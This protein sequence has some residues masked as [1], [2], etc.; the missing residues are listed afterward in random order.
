MS[1][2]T[3]FTRAGLAVF[4]ASAL[5]G[6]AFAAPAQAFVPTASAY[7][8]NF[9]AGNSNVSTSQFSQTAA[10]IVASDFNEHPGS[11]YKF[12]TNAACTGGFKMTSPGMLFTST[13]HPVVKM[14]LY[15]PEAASVNIKVETSSD[16]TIKAAKLV[17]LN[18]GWNLDVTV[19]FSTI[20]AWNV[21]NHYDTLTIFPGYSCSLSN[22]G[23][24]SQTYY[25][26]NIQA[27]GGDKPTPTIDSN[28]T[29]SDITYGDTLANSILSGGTADVAGSF[30]FTTPSTAPNAGTAAQGYTF[31]PTDTHNYRNATSSTNVT[32]NKADTS[33]TVVPS[34]SDLTYGDTL[35]NS[36][37]SG[38]SGSVPG[39][40]AFTSPTTAPNAGTAAQGV[41]FT[42][43]DSANYNTQSTLTNVTVNKADVSITVDP[44]ASDITYGDTLAN[45]NLSGGTASVAGSFAFTSPTTAPNAGTA[46]QGVTF[47]PA[48]TANYSPVTTS[49]N[50]K[51][52][53]ATPT[54]SSAPTG[55]TIQYGKTLGDSR[56]TGGLAS[57]PGTFG[58]A[59]T[60]SVPSVGDHQFTVVF[61]P[62][63]SDNY[64][65]VTVDVSVTVVGPWINSVTRQGLY[66]YVSFT[67]PT[68]EPGKKYDYVAYRINGG[69]WVNWGKFSKSVQKLTGMKPRLNLTVQIRAH[70][71]K[72]A[73]TGASNVVQFYTGGK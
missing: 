27:N 28:P 49:V 71:A 54:I 22:G 44:T 6:A 13:E 62:A 15:S 33:I 9:E 45:S 18:A 1:S 73:W 64:E 70:V 43:T 51:V 34:A 26:D 11:I 36:N 8:A 40:F 23:S 65:V 2:L 24:A 7:F 29:A 63:D 14:D 55:G 39:S 50:V 12:Q 52:N 30:A 10:G 48:D 42:P 16:G 38:G 3:K 25:V 53:K 69:K 56:L 19:D 57:V 67:L 20:G 35:A 31:T 66:N 37:L 68:L 61:T 32:V 58:F 47:T 41:T 21:A 72:G 60:S 5:A 46:A 4:T 59:D 17:K